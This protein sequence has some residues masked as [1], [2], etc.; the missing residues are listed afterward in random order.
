MRGWCGALLIAGLVC[1]AATPTAFAQTPRPDYTPYRQGTFLTFL[2]ASDGPIGEVPR[3]GLSFGGR[4]VRAELD[5]GST[6]IVVAADYVP[7]YEQMPSLGPGRVTYTSS[8]RVMLGS[9][10]TTPVILIGRMGATVQT[11]PMPVLV[12][13]EVR[14]L[15]EARDCT[16]SSQPR[17]IAMVGIGFAREHDAQSQGTPDRNPLLRIMGAGGGTRRTGYIV[18]RDGIQV[19]ITAAST[20]GDFRYIKLARQE[21]IPDWAPTPA[22]ISLNG[23]TPPACGSLL[24]DTGVPA[25]FITLPDTQAGDARRMLPDG[26]SVAV[27]VG[28]GEGAFDLYDFT[29]GGNSPLAPTTVHLRVAP[30]GAFLNTGFHLLNGYDVLFDAEEGYVGFRRR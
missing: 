21:S 24:V 22:C 6:G 5:T 14:C 10:L 2:N 26:T 1:V 11:E 28:S 7:G 17:G 27:R 30:D 20:Q 9:W 18:T 4:A 23:Q 15:E 25:A 13:T 19:G 29:V 8:G 12:V 3:I 16:P